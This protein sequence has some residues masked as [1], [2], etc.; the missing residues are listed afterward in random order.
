MRRKGLKNAK[1]V[2]QWGTTIATYAEPI[3]GKLLVRD[4]DVG[5]V[6][7]VVEPIW[8]R[9]PETAGRVRGR[10]EKILGW[11]K[12]H[13]YRDE[14]NP[15]RWRPAEINDARSFG[16]RGHELLPGARGRQNR[17]FERARCG[18]F[19]LA[20]LFHEGRQLGIGQRRMVFDP[21]SRPAIIYCR[22]AFYSSI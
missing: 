9:K 16:R 3:L 4:I 2:A 17:K 15:A 6:H 11:A 5:H 13:K 8:T 7:R 20:Q 21:Y 19:H 10:I 18:A 22:P 1:H 14:E 12:A